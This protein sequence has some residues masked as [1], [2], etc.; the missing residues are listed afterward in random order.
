M[1]ACSVLVEGDAALW[2]RDNDMSAMQKMKCQICG[3]VYDPS[4]KRTDVEPGIAFTDLP[5]SWRCP[6]CGAEK[7]NFKETA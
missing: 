6:V 2:R 3:H 5:D 4:K 7:K 1:R